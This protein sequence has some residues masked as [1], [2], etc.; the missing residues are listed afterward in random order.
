MTNR[1]SMPSVAAERPP[2]F[3]MQNCGLLPC[4]LVLAAAKKRPHV[5]LIILPAVLAH[6]LAQ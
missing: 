1:L 4:M 2:A 6:N 5:M 3:A